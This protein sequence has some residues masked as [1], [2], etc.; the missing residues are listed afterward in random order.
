VEVAGYDGITGT[1]PRTCCAWIRATTVANQNIMSWAQNATGQKWRVRVNGTGGLRAEV[2]GGYHYG[3]TNIADGLW[4]HVAVTFE[5]DGSPDVLDTL[6]YVDG[7]RDATAASQA[8]GIDTA[9][10]PVRIGKSPW[11]DDSF[12]DDIDDARIYDKVLTAEEIQQVMLA[13]LVA[14]RHGCFARRLLRYR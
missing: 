5:D 2:E 14:R 6:L 1:A 8:T 4:H 3:V 12:M 10:G 7:R 11:Y 9:A 13:E